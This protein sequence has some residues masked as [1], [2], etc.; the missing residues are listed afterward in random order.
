[1]TDLRR[2]ATV[3]LL[4]P[5]LATGTSTPADA[6]FFGRACTTIAQT[7]KLTALGVYGQGRTFCVGSSSNP[8][9]TEVQF[10]AL[11]GGRWIYLSP[12]EAGQGER[13][14]H[15]T[16]RRLGFTTKYRVRARNVVTET[17]GGSLVVKR[18]GWDQSPAVSW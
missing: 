9:R 5:L 13:R 2:A 7:P 11:I 1:M 18:G 16:V 10:Q 6:S 12:V 14:A 15:A 17:L 4:A 8:I 3:A